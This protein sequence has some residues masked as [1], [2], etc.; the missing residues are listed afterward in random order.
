MN[1]LGQQGV[2]YAAGDQWKN[3]SR[4]NEEMEPKREQHPVVDV[5]GDEFCIQNQINFRMSFGVEPC[6]CLLK[7]QVTSVHLFYFFPYY[8][9]SSHYPF[10]P[11]TQVA[12]RPQIGLALGKELWSESHREGNFKTEVDR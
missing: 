8:T 2:Q 1:S 4:K 3:N 7:A 5:T 10:S 11:E 9:F 12:Q 6:Q